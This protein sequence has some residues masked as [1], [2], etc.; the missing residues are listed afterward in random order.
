[1]VLWLV[2]YL[3]RWL[4]QGLVAISDFHIF[5]KLTMTMQTANMQGMAPLFVTGPYALYP[6]HVCSADAIAKLFVKTCARGNPIL[7]GKPAKDLHRLGVAFYKKSVGSLVS[8]VFLKEA[9][10]VAL[11]F[12]WDSF[13]GGVWEGTSPPESLAS[14][15]AIGAAMF[16]SRPYEITSPGQEMFMAYAGVAVP[17]PGPILSKSMQIMAFLSAAAAKYNH[18]FLYCVHAKTIEQ[19]QNSVRDP[20]G[21]LWHVSYSDIEVSDQAV[22]EEICSIPGFAECT[23]TGLAFSEDQICHGPEQVVQEIAEG[24]RLGVARMVSSSFV[25]FED[26]FRMPVASL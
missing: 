20:E 14:H 18:S 4:A 19:S 10:P 17:H 11:Y 13:N 22:R 2:S 26:G 7:Q 8:L 5:C 16:T 15:A 3:V 25:Q 1:L 6:L 23:A 21:H 24:C 12:G 9:E